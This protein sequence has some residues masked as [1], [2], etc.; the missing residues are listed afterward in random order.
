MIDINIVKLTGTLGFAPE[1]RVP[2]GQHQSGICTF[3]LTTVRSFNDGEED[4]EYPLYHRC[5]V[6]GKLASEIKD[7]CSKGDRMSVEG[8]L[9][10]RSWE[11]KDG[12]KNYMT[13]VVVEKFEKEMQSS[14]VDEDDDIPF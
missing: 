1:I 2:A 10:T 12:K 3:S 4:K 8:Y 9:K 7:N 6:F 5:V 11:G 13:E 14:T